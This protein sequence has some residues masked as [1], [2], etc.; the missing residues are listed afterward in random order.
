MRAILFTLLLCALGLGAGCGQESGE[1]NDTGP[2]DSGTGGSANDSGSSDSGTG[3]TANHSGSGGSGNDPGSGAS[4]SGGESGG[5]QSGGSGGSPSEGGATSGGAGGSGGAPGGGAGGVV[6]AERQERLTRAQAA[7]SPEAQAAARL[8]AARPAA[9][10]EARVVDRA[11]A[12]AEVVLAAACRIGC[13]TAV[14]SERNRRNRR[15]VGAAARVSCVCMAPTRR[16]RSTGSSATTPR[17]TIDSIAAAL[18]YH[19]FALS[20]AKSGDD[21][22]P[23]WIS[24]RSGDSGHSALIALRMQQAR[25][26]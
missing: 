21:G 8:T 24:S 23:S 11:V 20:A 26:R 15:A 17:R 12:S 14:F 5:S 2:S 22:S 25:H 13:P 9:V 3:G 7:V 1:Q 4:P 10:R 6:L 19:P 16:S 18:L